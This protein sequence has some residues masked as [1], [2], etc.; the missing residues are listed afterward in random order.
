MKRHGNLWP[1]LTSFKHL[2]RSSEKAKRGKRFRPAVARYE[3]NLERELWKLR[4]QLQKRTYR[5]GHYR[6]FYIYEPKKR[7]ISA[8]PYRDRIVHHALTGV[9]EPIFEPTFISNSYACRKGKGTHAAVNRCQQFARR[10]RYVFKADIR[11]FFPSM[12][13]AI[14]K[15]QVARKI[16]DPDVLW[17]SGLIIDGSNPQEEVRDHFPGDDLLTPGE[18]RRGI[19]IG[20]QTSQFFANVYLDPLDHFVKERLRFKG[21]VRYVDDFLLFSDDKRQLNE[22]RQQI[23]EFLIQLRLKLHSRKN[24]IFPVEEGIRFLGYRVFP[25]HRL[26]AK[27]NVWRFVRRVRRMQAQY[28]EG[29]IGLPEIKQRLMSWSGHARQ[30]DTHRLRT[31]LFDTI[32]FRR[33]TAE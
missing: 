12:D 5:P 7:L 11:K 3:F 27:E 6:S 31:Y 17:L 15:E 20:N 23:S 29:E 24:T 16:K 26:L 2:L 25:T 32:A 28:R 14:L 8:A 22:A 33:A 18:R 30:A 4:E 10:F 21:Y 13:H 19:P 9:L 1:T